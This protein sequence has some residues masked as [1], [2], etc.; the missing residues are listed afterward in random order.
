MNVQF[1]NSFSSSNDAQLGN[2]HSHEQGV[3][4][5]SH[6]H[7]GDHG[8]THEHLDNAGTLPVLSIPLY[9]SNSIL[10]SGKFSERD[11]PDYSARNFQERGFTIG[12]GG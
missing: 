1:I 10:P 7:G 8:H 4:P 5:H 11:M 2:V 9:R 12:I 3:A 6:D